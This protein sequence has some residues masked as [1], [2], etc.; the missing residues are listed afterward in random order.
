MSLT[1][2]ECVCVC[3]FPPFVLR[4]VSDLVLIDPI[5]EDLFEEDQWKEYW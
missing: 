2:S 4:H 3:V 5:P 1:S